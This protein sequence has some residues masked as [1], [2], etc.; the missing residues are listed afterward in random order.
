MANVV[1]PLTPALSLKELVFTHKSSRWTPWVLGLNE[2]GSNPNPPNPKSETNSKDRKSKIQDVHRHSR[3][4][5]RFIGV[6]FVSNLGFVS[7]F[8]SS[9]AG[10]R[11]APSFPAIL[12][13]VD[14]FRISDFFARPTVSSQKDVGH[15]QPR[16]RVGVREKG[17]IENSE[18]TSCS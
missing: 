15:A 4:S 18:A 14:E 9:V 12:R 3:E 6:F 7:D 8:P 2:L 13:R 1:F 17:A 16:Q 5:G 10:S 11:A